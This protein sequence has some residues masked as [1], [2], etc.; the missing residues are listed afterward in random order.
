MQFSY[1]AFSTDKEPFPHKEKTWSLPLMWRWLL[2]S[3][4]GGTCLFPWVS[5]RMWL[6][7]L[8]HQPDSIFVFYLIY[9][10]KSHFGSFSTAPPPPAL[11]HN[12]ILYVP[13]WESPESIYWRVMV[14]FYFEGAKVFLE[15]IRKRGKVRQNVYVKEKNVVL[16]GCFPLQLTIGRL[17][18]WRILL[19]ISVYL[20]TLWVSRGKKKEE[21]EVER[22]DAL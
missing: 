12:N 7:L 20:F 3:A 1:A 8:D 14:S 6:W 22:K 5:I 9:Q 11:I 18:H 2:L 17:P 19:Q 21:K 4:T 16:I 15:P 10:H 13:L